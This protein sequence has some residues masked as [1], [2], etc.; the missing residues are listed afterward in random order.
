M[1][2][3]VHNYSASSQLSLCM[4]TTVE[5]RYLYLHVFKASAERD[6][7]PAYSTCSLIT[8]KESC[9]LIIK[10]T[11]YWSPI[12]LITGGHSGL[13]VIMSELHQGWGFASCLWPVHGVYKCPP[14]ALGCPLGY[15]GPKTCL[16]DW[17]A[18]FNFCD[19]ACDMMAPGPGCHH[20]LS[21]LK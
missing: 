7:S 10:T 21:P 1:T 14:H 20:A 4:G 19:F 13:V 16:I 11:T 18:I 6:E 9:H 17:L 5:L 2:V 15:S 8:N 3:F 12:W